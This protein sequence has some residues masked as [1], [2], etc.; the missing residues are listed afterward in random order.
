M[1]INYILFKPVDILASIPDMGKQ[2]SIRIPQ[3]GKLY[4]SN[5]FSMDS[6][7]HIDSNFH[8]KVSLGDSLL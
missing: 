1:Y 8:A 2:I 6:Q 7:E 3:Y 5:L 4:Y